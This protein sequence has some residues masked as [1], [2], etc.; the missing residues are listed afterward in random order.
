MKLPEVNFKVLQFSRTDIENLFASGGRILAGA[1]PGPFSDT[2]KTPGEKLGGLIGIA[3]ANL[4]FGA[5]E[6]LR[7]VLLETILKLSAKLMLADSDASPEERFQLDRAI[8]DGRL[9]AS[10]REKLEQLVNETLS[11]SQGVEQIARDFYDKCPKQ[12]TWHAKI[13][14]VLLSVA[15]ADGQFD[16]REDALIL[17]VANV[18]GFTEEEYLSKKFEFAS[19]E[20]ELERYY[21]LLGCE[22]SDRDEVLE[23]KYGDVLQ[24][25][26]PDKLKSAGMAEKYIQDAE[27]SFREIQKGYSMIMCF[28]RMAE[29]AKQKLATAVVPPL[30]GVQQEPTFRG[31]LQRT[32]LFQAAGIEAMREVIWKFKAGGPI[33]DSP[34]ISSDYLVFGSQDH[35]IYC[36]ERQT[37][38]ER[39]RFRTAGE[40]LG[41][42]IVSQGTAYFGC[43]VGTVHAVE[44]DTGAEL[45]KFESQGAVVGCPAVWEN[46][47]T[48]YFGSGDAFLYSL[49][50]QTGQLKWS[51]EAEEAIRSSPSI[52]D[53]V[54]YF[55]CDDGHLFAVNMAGGQ[56]K[57]RF[58]SRQGVIFASPIRHSPAVT[59]TGFVYFGNTD[60]Q[61]YALN[62]RLGHPVW[63][64]ELDSK[65]RTCPAISGKMLLVGT[66]HLKALDIITGKEI[67]Q[68]AEEEATASPS[69]A[70]ETVYLGTSTGMHALDLRSGNKKWSFA[71]STPVSS[72]PFISDGVI[73]FGCTDGFVYALS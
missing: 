68:Y 15:C 1:I 51:F 53:G 30:E 64:V 46:E 56:E 32:G 22:R 40:E 28:R 50:V 54:I 11:S 18:F 70:G 17:Q 67:W 23:Q 4:I 2:L 7:A 6:K 24:Q 5:D 9:E 44:I 8:D 19:D 27:K 38:S 12:R 45:W 3:I 10:Q 34:I 41:S 66:S 13:I 35:F 25:H 48:I 71:T 62:A 63:S 52:L 55:G 69:I 73:Y 49:D 36:V 47:K 20:S 60:K 39:W 65:I 37:G 29:E 59:R 57:W 16:P 21:E 61:F 43:G 72:S 31:N 58:K 14:E 33:N 26:H 42:A